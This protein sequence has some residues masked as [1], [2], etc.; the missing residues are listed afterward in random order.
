MAGN[1]KETRNLVHEMTCTVSVQPLLPINHPSIDIISSIKKEAEENEITE[2]IKGSKYPALN[3]MLSTLFYVKLR[4][5][6][7]VHYWCL[8]SAGCNGISRLRD[9]ILFLS[10]FFFT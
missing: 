4:N 1:T 9:P 8:D 10:H 7:N 5:S 2:T 3:R 6:N